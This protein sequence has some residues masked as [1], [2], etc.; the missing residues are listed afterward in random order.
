M[1]G[2]TVKGSSTAAQ[3]GAAELRRSAGVSQPSVCHRG[4]CGSER[5]GGRDTRLGGHTL[6]S[7]RA[8]TSRSGMAPTSHEST[9]SAGLSRSTHQ[10]SPSR[11]VARLT[12][13]TPSGRRTTA[14]PPRRG[15]DPWRTSSRCP[16]YNVGS[17]E[18]PRTTARP[19]RRGAP[20]DPFARRSNAAT[21]LLMSPPGPGVVS[22]VASRHLHKRPLD[23]KD[24]E[25]YPDCSHRP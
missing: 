19:S 22:Q 1:S 11:R 8:T 4:P 23:R 18:R 10:P 13:T 3:G 12:A 16:S 14:S 2:E 25:C 24:N 6:R 15:A 7:T 5:C 20:A 9:P 21:P 17:I